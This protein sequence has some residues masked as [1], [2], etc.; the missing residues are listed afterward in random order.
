MVYRSPFVR[1]IEKRGCIV[2]SVI[3]VFYMFVYD[4]PDVAYL[5]V[6]KVFQIHPETVSGIGIKERMNNY[7]IIV[8]EV[9]IMECKRAACL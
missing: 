5:F 2:L 8:Y 9:Y 1:F 4:L 3:R 6:D 7:K